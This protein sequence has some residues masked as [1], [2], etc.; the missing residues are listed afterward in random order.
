MPAAAKPWRADNYYRPT[1]SLSRRDFL[2]LTCGLAAGGCEAVKETSKPAGGTGGAEH[3]VDAGPAAAYSADGLYAA[4]KDQGFFLR[5]QGG[6]LV[7]LSSYCT[8]RRCKL[9][10][11]PDRSF[12]CHC[13]GSTFSP[14]GK[15]TEGPATR[16]LPAFRSFAGPNGHLMVAIPTA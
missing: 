2:T 5:R 13:H 15:V 7:A 1:M 14:D 4:F 9:T 12:Y 8:H 11:E 10:E 6:V 16:D 3:V